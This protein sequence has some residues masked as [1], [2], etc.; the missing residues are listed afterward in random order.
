MKVR[1]ATR[2]REVLLQY[3]RLWSADPE[4]YARALSLLWESLQ[5]ESQDEA[6]GAHLGFQ[7]SPREHVRSDLILSSPTVRHALQRGIAFYNAANPHSRYAL[8]QRDCGMAL[9]VHHARPASTVRHDTEMRLALWAALIRWFDPQDRAPLLVRLRAPQPAY[10]RELQATFGCAVAYDQDEDAVL[11]DETALEASIWGSE[12]VARRLRDAIGVPAEAAQRPLGLTERVAAAIREGL[13]QGRAGIK[14]VAPQF[15]V[16]PRTLERR[17]AKA[18]VSYREVLA[19][20][21]FERCLHLIQVRGLP[22]WELANL[23][24]FSNSSNFFRAFCRWIAPQPDGRHGTS[25]AAG[26]GAR[27]A[28]SPAAKW[29]TAL[30]PRPCPFTSAACRPRCAIHPAH[31]QRQ[32]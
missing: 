6:I 1:T 11:V 16:S 30:G 7:F 26:S 2:L 28:L 14:T 3:E 5:Y 15:G 9:S 10:D 8:E 17:L 29:T 22:T 31:W 20:V 21:R 19:E 12:Y 25:G 4:I 18:S 13:S 32:S 24:G 23:L 27:Q